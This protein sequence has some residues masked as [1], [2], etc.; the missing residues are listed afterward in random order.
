MPAAS[1][2][3]GCRN[4]NKQTNK[5]TK[6]YKT[7]IRGKRSSTKSDLMYLS[8]GIGQENYDTFLTRA[9]SHS[10]HVM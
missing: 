8:I 6:V 7:I 2:E 9:A 1:G 4:R 10:F 3:G 5:T